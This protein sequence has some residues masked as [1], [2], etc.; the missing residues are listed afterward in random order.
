MGCAYY[1]GLYADVAAYRDWIEE[2]A[3]PSCED[4]EDWRKTDE[5]DKD[6]KWVAGK[7]AT[8][9]SARGETPGEGTG[10]ILASYACKSVCGGPCQDGEWHKTGE[11]RK[12]CAWVSSFP[13]A[14]CK[15]WGE[16]PGEE[17]RVRAATACPDSCA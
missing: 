5:P 2:E 13:E 8:R 11:D 14:R 3:G 10:K 12:G 9:C 1:P 7:P 17:G 4:C 15:V 16:V 6:C